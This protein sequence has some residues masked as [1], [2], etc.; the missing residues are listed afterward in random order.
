MTASKQFCDQLPVSTALSGSL[1]LHVLHCYAGAA[2]SAEDMKIRFTAGSYYILG[3][4]KLHLILAYVVLDYV[5]NKYVHFFMCACSINIFY[6][7]D[8]I[9]T[10]AETTRSD[11]YVG[12]N[13]R[14]LCLT[15]CADFILDRA[16]LSLLI[17]HLCTS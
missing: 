8:C 12:N 10:Y 15:R 11:Y 17:H 1:N 9:F 3:Y 6:Y 13:V 16:E 4:M 14:E 5:I 7:V 2:E